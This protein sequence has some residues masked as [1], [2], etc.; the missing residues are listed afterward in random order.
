MMP[1]QGKLRP[2]AA[3]A[4]S[5]VM[6]ALAAVIGYLELL[7]PINMFGIPGVKPG[8]ANIV[9]LIALYMLGPVYAYMIMCVRVLLLGAMFGN[10]YSVIYSLTGGLISITVMLILKR[11]NAF[12]AAGISAAGGAFHNIGQLC[13]AVMS[14]G[15]LNLV[16]YVPVLVISGTL[17]GCLTGVLTVIL[18]E[19]LSKSYAPYMR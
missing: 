18:I 13:V 16:Y 7:M 8:L 10:M 17:F 6:T 4:Y 3:A 9:S 15:S 2:A 5:S 12:G 14:L 11:T 19:R 1:L